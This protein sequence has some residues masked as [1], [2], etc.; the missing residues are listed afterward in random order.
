[1]A[2]QRRK[3]TV[4]DRTAIGLRLRDGWGIRQIAL[5]LGRSAGTVS[6]EVN[7]NGG[8]AAY[9]AGAA[10]GQASAKRELTGRTPKMAR[11]GALF[12]EAARLLRLGWSPEQISDRRKREKAGMERPPAFACR[13]RRSTPR[14][15]PCR[16][17]SCGAN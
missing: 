5:A 13:T 12:T 15:M 6:D 4:V 16:A 8:Q 2:A 3:L 1:M 11:N 14:S 17:A 10:E 9:D 7:R